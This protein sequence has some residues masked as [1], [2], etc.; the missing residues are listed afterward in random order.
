MRA[1]GITV[2][3]KSFTEETVRMYNGLEQVKI[4]SD[5]VVVGQEKLA[6]TK[7]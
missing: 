3:K 7:P 2:A 5:K 1:D 6:T 4:K